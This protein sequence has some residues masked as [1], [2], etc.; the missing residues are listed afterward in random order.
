MIRAVAGR[1]PQEGDMLTPRLLAITLA[2]I[3]AGTLAA[4]GSSGSS[5]SSATSTATAAPP[6]DLK[7]A[8]QAAFDAHP[9]THIV[10]TYDDC[11]A[12][13]NAQAAYAY[14]G[15]PEA[16]LNHYTS[17]CL[18]VTWRGS[19]VKP[20]A[21]GD[22]VRNS[23]NIGHYIVDTVSDPVAGTAG[24]FTIPITAH[25]IYS[26]DGKILAAKDQRAGQL[27]FG[28]ATPAPMP[29]GS[30][31]ATKAA[32]GTWNITIPNLQM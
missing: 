23:L 18:K 17:T 3:F 30:V 16:H 29:S 13:R 27:G 15:I 26:A 28:S 24:L 32:D 8:V 5:G 31:V 1:V 9:A 14:G 25:F 20:F 21:P 7:A 2:A 22:P 4:C 19:N 11:N 10:F 6:N 12:A